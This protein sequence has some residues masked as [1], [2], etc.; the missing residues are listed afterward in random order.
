MNIGKIVRIM[1]PGRLSGRRILG[2]LILLGCCIGSGAIAS[3]GERIPIDKLLNFSEVASVAVLAYPEEVL[4]RAALSPDF[5]RKNYTAE[6]KVERTQISEW[7]KFSSALSKS[8]FI[9]SNKDGD[10][11]WLLVFFNRSGKEVAKLA[12]DREKKVAKM[13]RNNYLVKGPLLKWIVSIKPFLHD[14]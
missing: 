13:D 7:S 11:R 2:V 9:A 14:R 1:C 3:D 4:V 8:T 12:V 10:F 6:T 5:L